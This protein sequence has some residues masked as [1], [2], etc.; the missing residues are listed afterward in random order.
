MNKHSYQKMKTEQRKITMITCYDYPSARIIDQTN[1]DIILVGDS[2][3]MVVHGYPD[4][5]HATV[6]MISTHTSA[7]RRGTKKFIVADM[8]FMSFRKSQE[9]TLNNVQ[10]LITAGANAVKL[11]GAAGNLELITHIVH[12]GVPVIGH[13]GLTP[14]HVNQLGGFRVQGRDESAQRRLIAEA[15]QLEEAGC[16]M[17]VLECVPTTLAKKITKALSIPTI[18]IGAGVHTDGQVLVWHDLLG[19]QTEFQPK[20]VKRYLEGAT[21][22]QNAIEA[23]D[24][25]VKRA[26][27]PCDSHSF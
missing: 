8:P 24:S 2:A 13:I 1:V 4:T 10:Q 6:D 11:E 17:L 25:E 16:F 15:K 20:F 21:L 7:V 9:D 19:I 26:D 22:Y 18:G 12:S 5:T 14:Q 27:F 23:Y 3:A